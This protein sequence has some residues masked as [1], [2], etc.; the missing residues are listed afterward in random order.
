MERQFFT[1]H[2]DWL[3]GVR[4]FVRSFVRSPVRSVRQGGPALSQN[5]VRYQSMADQNDA[6]EIKSLEDLALLNEENAI[7]IEVNGQEKFLASNWLQGNGRAS[8]SI[9]AKQILGT[10]QGLSGTTA[11]TID[12]EL[13]PVFDMLILWMAIGNDYL[14]ASLTEENASDL[15]ALASYYNLQTLE[16]AIQEEQHRRDEAARQEE[17]K[18]RQ[19]K[20]L[21][22]ARIRAAQEGKEKE[23]Q[24]Q[25][26]ARSR[27]RAVRTFVCSN[28]SSNNT[29]DDYCAT[30]MSLTKVAYSY[31]GNRPRC[32][33]CRR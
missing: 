33:S 29:F 23:R 22:R 1:E 3:D 15:F 8:S 31:Q 13:V 19:R 27:N 20:E 25:E 21:V 2:G 17:E 16:K 26:R 24:R 14:Q 11:L 6:P 18:E 10:K 28:Y 9:L 32:R 30:C 5:Y 4:S 7:R 12:D